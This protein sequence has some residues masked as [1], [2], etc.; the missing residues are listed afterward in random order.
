MSDYLSKTF[1]TKSKIK[2]LKENG[3]PER[4]YR[5]RLLRGWTPKK[6]LNTPYKEKKSQ[7]G[8][9]LDVAYKNGVDK[10]FHQRIRSGYTP[11][12]AAFLNKYE[13]MKGN[14]NSSENVR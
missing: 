12:D 13:A 1:L 7:Y 6:A 2:K 3:I 5:S 9:L 8:D 4:I 11:N 14:K 10:I